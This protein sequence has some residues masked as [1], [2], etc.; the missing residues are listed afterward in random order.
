MWAAPCTPRRGLLAGTARGRNEATLCDYD[1]PDKTCFQSKLRI[2][3]TELGMMYGVRGVRFETPMSQAGYEKKPDEV[4]AG[5]TCAVWYRPASNVGVWRWEGID[6][7]LSNMPDKPGGYV[8][9]AT[10]YEDLDAIPVALLEP[11]EG[12]TIK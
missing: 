10:A 1:K 9:E 4:I 7:K 11:P 6:L 12:F 2:K 8:S 3:A 5:T